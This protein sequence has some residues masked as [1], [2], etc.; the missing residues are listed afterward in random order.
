VRPC[1]IILSLRPPPP[2]RLVV[3]HQAPAAPPSP[4]A[5]TAL[6]PALPTF[7]FLVP[8]LRT[9]NSEAP[10]NSE[11][12]NAER[13]LRNSQSQ[14]TRAARSRKALMRQAR[15]QPRRWGLPLPLASCLRDLG[16]GVT[17]TSPRCLCKAGAFS[18]SQQRRPARWNRTP[19][20]PRTSGSH[21]PPSSRARA[22]RP[23]LRRRAC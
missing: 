22:H 19:P 1:R 14:F 8:L 9:L 2:P 16:P 21:C 13:R 12:R 4:P 17:A 11:L 15:N 10:R 20:P 6:P 23:L 3:V 5:G 18:H 7:P